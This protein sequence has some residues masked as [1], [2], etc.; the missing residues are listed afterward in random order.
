MEGVERVGK[1]VLFKSETFALPFFTPSVIKRR[2][3]HVLVHGEVI[4]TRST[5]YIELFYKFLLPVFLLFPLSL[6]T[7]FMAQKTF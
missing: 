5:F 1:F 3:E 4:K 6:C 7:L 2:G